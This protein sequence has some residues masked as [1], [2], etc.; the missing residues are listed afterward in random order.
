MFSIRLSSSFFVTNSS[1]L[2]SVCVSN[3]IL[4]LYDSSRKSTPYDERCIPV[5]TTSLYPE[6]AS[7]FTSSMIF[8]IFLLLT[9]PLVKGIIQYE[10]N[11]LQP[12]CTFIKALVW[13]FILLI[14]NSSYSVFLFISIM[15]LF[16]FLSCKYSFIIFTISF[17]LLFPTIISML[18]SSSIFSF[19]D[20]T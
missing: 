7:F 10:Q 4:L 18:R 13:S 3:S 14:L 5:S 1:S 15:N 12:S 8:S 19:A 16:S 9:L 17:L 2:S 6:D 11:W 20:S